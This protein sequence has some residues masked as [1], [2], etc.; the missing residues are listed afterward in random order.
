M[1]TLDRTCLGFPGWFGSGSSGHCQGLEREVCAV[2][3]GVGVPTR[4]LLPD[5]LP[6]ALPQ[7]SENCF[8]CDSQGRGGHGIEN[9]ISRNGPDG[10]K[11]WWQ[12]E[13]SEGAGVRV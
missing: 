9:V 7:D 8:F 13:S 1:R 6:W 4:H 2:T 3:F 5:P 10:S 12:A 11:T